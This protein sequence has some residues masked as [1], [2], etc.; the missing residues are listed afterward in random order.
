MKNNLHLWICIS[1]CLGIIGW[2]VGQKN[3]VSKW[4]KNTHP[5]MS[6]AWYEFGKSLQTYFFPLIIR[7]AMDAHGRWRAVEYVSLGF[8]NYDFGEQLIYPGEA[9]PFHYEPFTGD[10][11][12]KVRFKILGVDRFY[13]SEPF[14]GY[15]D[16]GQFKEAKGAMS[17]YHY[18]MEE[19]KHF[20]P[21]RG[22]TCWVE[23]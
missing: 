14:T 13:Y 16:Y 22:N 12:T 15:I 17:K 21:R 4:E 18:K 5:A 3:Q 1:A 8:P 11:K 9:L 10:Y 6:L 7:E 23:D 19:F 2:G 20:A